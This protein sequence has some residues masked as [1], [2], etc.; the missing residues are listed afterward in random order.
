MMCNDST[1]RYTACANAYICMYVYIYIHMYTFTFLS[2][3]L[4]QTLIQTPTHLPFTGGEASW[5][6]SPVVL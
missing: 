1:D 5:R 4:P 3:L 2:P 6:I